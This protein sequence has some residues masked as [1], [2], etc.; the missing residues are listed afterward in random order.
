MK[1]FLIGALLLVAVIAM[2]KTRDLQ[3]WNTLATSTV[4]P[5]TR[6]RINT[7][8]FNSV[9]NVCRRTYCRSKSR[10]IHYSADLP[11]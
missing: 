11:I 7:K 9:L 3:T 8:W 5:F 10:C 4:T 2:V 6:R 1:K